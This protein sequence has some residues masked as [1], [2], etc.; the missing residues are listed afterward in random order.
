MKANLILLFFMVL[1]SSLMA[2]NKVGYFYYK[3]QKTDKSL[4]AV[5]HHFSV[6]MKEVKQLSNKK[7]DVIYVDERLKIP[8]KGL[9]VHK[10]SSK[11]KSFW[12]ISQRY[13]ID[14][15]ALLKF[16][17]KSDAIIRTAEYLVFPKS[18]Q[19]GQRKVDSYS[20]MYVYQ[21]QTYQIYVE[22]EKADVS[23]ITL[24]LYIRQDGHWQLQ[25]KV[26]GI[27]ATT[28]KHYLKKEKVF[29][30]LN[31]DGIK[32]LRFLDQESKKYQYFK[33]DLNKAEIIK[34]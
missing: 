9:F 6:D 22:I 7:E 15:K 2:Q 27:K 17:R 5:C 8:A 19:K 20:K 12:S 3:V 11:D 1:S 29:R 30:D 23:H 32:D 18:W 25:D 33:L 4:W 31:K 28:S 21:K 10:V 24:S 13:G 16:N 14:Y 34:F 26:D